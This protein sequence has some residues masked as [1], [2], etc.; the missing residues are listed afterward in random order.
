MS[1]ASRVVSECYD[2]TLNDVLNIYISLYLWM[3]VLY[4][5][6]TLDY[7]CGKIE[8]WFPGIGYIQTKALGRKL[9]KLLW[10]IAIVR[11]SVLRVYKATLMFSSDDASRRKKRPI[12]KEK[13]VNV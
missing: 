7:S 8:G 2:T 13:Y 12:K 1:R 9:V 5:L 10:Y 6:D 3:E 11:A 4:Y